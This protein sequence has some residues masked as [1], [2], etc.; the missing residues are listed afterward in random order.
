MELMAS[1]LYRCPTTGKNVQAWFDDDSLDDES[2]TYVS[3]RCP[4]C[5]RVHIVN[6]AGERP[7]DKH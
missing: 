4:A 2:L 7:G 1:V 6:R 3:L 5:A